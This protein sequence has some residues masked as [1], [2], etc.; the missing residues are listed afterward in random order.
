MGEALKAQ[1]YCDYH[2]HQQREWFILVLCVIRLYFF[3][4]SHT[5]PE[6]AIDPIIVLGMATRI[7]HEALFVSLFLISCILFHSLVGT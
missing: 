7:G 4:V 6:H 5:R 3:P 1:T 2:L